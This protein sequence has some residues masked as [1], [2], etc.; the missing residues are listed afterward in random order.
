MPGNNTSILWHTWNLETKIT[1][2]VQAMETEGQEH[3]ICVLSLMWET[4]LHT[5]TKHFDDEDF[6]PRFCANILL[7]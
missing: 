1:P 2:K 3:A 4:Q 6:K 5:H 7:V